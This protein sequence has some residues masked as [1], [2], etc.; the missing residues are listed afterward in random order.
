MSFQEMYPEALASFAKAAT[1]DP[2]LPA[3]DMRS[4]LKRHSLKIL[5][6]VKRKVSMTTACSSETCLVVLMICCLTICNVI[7]CFRVALNQN[8]CVNC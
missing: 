5:D 1:I 6:M 2:S 8:G 3:E 4:S 7:V